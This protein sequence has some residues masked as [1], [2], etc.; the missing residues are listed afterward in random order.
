MPIPHLGGRGR[1]PREPDDVIDAEHLEVKDSSRELR[2]L[3]LWDGG[4]G[5]GQEVAL[6]AEAE[7]VAGA[8][9]AGAT[10]SL[11]RRLFARGGYDE[12]LESRHRV[13]DALLGEA[14]VDDK[15]DALDGHAR[16]GH[17]RRHHAL[18]PPAAGGLQARHLLRPR[19]APVQWQGLQ[20]QALAP[21]VV[22]AARLLSD[23][24]H[25][26]LALL[27]PRQKHQDVPRGPLPAS[28]ASASLSPVTPPSVVA[29]GTL[30]D[31]PA[32]YLCILSTVSTAA[33]T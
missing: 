32:S 22:R 13:V 9:A 6:G 30:V 27:L 17:V 16:L 18:A 14:A 26:R 5:K 19:Q 33:R 4:G 21:L 7:A 20:L 10:G 11:L 12:G 8:D 28:G 31:E 29:H 24:R 1:E 25:R 3:H 23:G 2:S 15:D